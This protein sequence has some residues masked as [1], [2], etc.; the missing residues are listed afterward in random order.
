MWRLR[1]LRLLPFVGPLRHLLGVSPAEAGLF[2]LSAGLVGQRPA[3]PPACA[4]QPN[5]TDRTRDRNPPASWHVEITKGGCTE[6][7]MQS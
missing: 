1:R 7:G 3:L 5:S 4:K 2:F 6:R